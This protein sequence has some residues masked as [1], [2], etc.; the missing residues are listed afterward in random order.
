MEIKQGKPFTLL[1]P[2]PDACQV[3]GRRHHPQM[4][5]GRDSMYYQTS[6][7]Q[8]RERS[9]TWSDAMAHCGASLQLEYRIALRDMFKELKQ[10]T[11]E[12]LIEKFDPKVERVQ[13]FRLRGMIGA[14]IVTNGYMQYQEI[15][16]MFTLELPF[17][18]S[19]L[20]G[21]EIAAN[22]IKV[23]QDYMRQYYSDKYSK[24]V[25]AGV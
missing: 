18:V 13:L 20:I 4:M 2:A 8:Q 1:P 25:V 21:N 16:E 12:D 7:Y 15:A 10:N 6:F 24:I 11:P 9:P 23:A 3:C 19:Y 5:H 17:E 22:Q 14:D